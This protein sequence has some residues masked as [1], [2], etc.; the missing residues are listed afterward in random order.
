MLLCF[1]FSN[2]FLISNNLAIQS[3]QKI[4][5]TL[6]THVHYVPIP[7]DTAEVITSTN[8]GSTNSLWTETTVYAYSGSKGSSNTGKTYGAYALEGRGSVI[9]KI[10]SMDRANGV[11]K[12]GGDEGSATAYTYWNK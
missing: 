2:I 7:N 1:N 3:W 10:R 12:G 6:N 9:A 4:H 11:H 8:I 5:G